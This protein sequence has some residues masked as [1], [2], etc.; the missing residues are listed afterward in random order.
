MCPLYRIT[1]MILYVLV[2]SVEY[3]EPSILCVAKESVHIPAD[4]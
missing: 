3:S 1:G 2:M 4:S